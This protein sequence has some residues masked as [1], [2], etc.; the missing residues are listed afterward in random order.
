MRRIFSRVR[1]GGGGVL[2]VLAILLSVF[3]AS[4]GVLAF[5]TPATRFSSCWCRESMYG[6]QSSRMN[7]PGFVH[8]P[9]GHAVPLFYQFALEGRCAGSD[10]RAFGAL[11]EGHGVVAVAGRH[12]AALSVWRIVGAFSTL[13]RLA[14]QLPTKKGAL[15]A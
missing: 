11:V 2:V 1:G 9:Y 15:A 7:Q 8:I 6:F 13:S 12:L 5:E 10:S 4:A 3:L 14:A